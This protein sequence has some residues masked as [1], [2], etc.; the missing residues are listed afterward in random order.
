[1]TPAKEQSMLLEQNQLRSAFL[2]SRKSNRPVSPKSAR[3]GNWGLH[4]QIYSFKLIEYF[5]KGLVL[6]PR[7]MTLRAYLAQQLHCCPILVSKKLGSGVLLGCTLPRH[8]GRTAFSKSQLP[9]NE[10]HKLTQEANEELRRLRRFC[11]HKN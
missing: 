5:L 3:G 9:T 6:A 11:F 1:M 2:A 8:I 4:E 7:G 10:V